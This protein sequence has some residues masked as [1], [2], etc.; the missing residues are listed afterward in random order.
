VPGRAIL[1]A[2]VAAAVLAVVLYYGHFGDVYATARNAGAP[3]DTA[4]AAPSFV[5]RALDAARY[6]VQDVGW[7]I[8]VLAG[9]GLWRIAADRSLDRLTLTLAG[10]A[11]AYVVF[12]ALGTLSPVNARYERYAAEFISRVDFATYPA[13]VVLAARGG[14]WIWRRGPAGRV[15][16]LALW[17]S[18]AVIGY[19]HWARWLS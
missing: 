17:F 9:V 18:A 11:G 8:V 1:T 7:P 12:A 2:T 5:S 14:L 6:G 16:V 19:Q 3:I 15:V 13:V 4:M 10:W